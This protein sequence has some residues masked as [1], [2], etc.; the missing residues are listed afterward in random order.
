MTWLACSLLLMG[1]QCDTGRPQTMLGG[2]CA[3]C[4]EREAVRD[5]W[6]DSDK[7]HANC[8]EGDYSSP[9]GDTDNEKESCFPLP[10]PCPLQMRSVS[11]RFQ[12]TQKTKVI[13][14]LKLRICCRWQSCLEVMLWTEPV[15]IRKHQEAARNRGQPG[16]RPKYF[17]HL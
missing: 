3:H 15:D 10:F 12:I 5:S 8:R 14:S 2:G 11:V 17:W 13:L 7:L 9:W 16:T 6:N 1:P 4:L